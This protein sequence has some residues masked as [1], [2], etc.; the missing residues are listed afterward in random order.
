[1][2]EMKETQA[3]SL[4]W[5]DPLEKGMATHS[6]IPNYIKVNLYYIQLS[7]SFVV[8]NL[9]I[10]S[11]LFFY[12]KPYIS[13]LI[14]SFPI[15][16]VACSLDSLLTFPVGC[17][18]HWILNSKILKKK[19]F[20][21]AFIKHQFFLLLLSPPHFS[22]LGIF[23]ALC[24]SPPSHHLILCNMDSTL[25]NAA[26][27]K[28]HQKT[29]DC[30]VQ[31]SNGLS[32]PEHLDSNS[33]NFFLFLDTSLL[34]LELCLLSPLFS[35]TTL[36]FSFIA[37]LP[38]KI[39]IYWSSMM[40]PHLFLM[41]TLKMILWIYRFSFITYLKLASQ[42]FP[43]TLASFLSSKPVCA[44][45]VVSESLWPCGPTRLLCS[46]GFSRKEYWIGLP[47]PPPGDLPN[48]GIEP[49]SPD[50]RQILYH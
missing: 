49:R 46:W 43:Q 17:L 6:S 38:L 31:W 39:F 41:Y 47:C 12:G 35:L 5:E 20:N 19:V 25:T 13:L 27:F 30:S 48:L 9:N 45:S 7:N 21:S 32:S 22:K 37:I 10:W 11:S 36:S 24:S 50:G 18:T 3:R 29:P 8:Y 33:I 42:L 40:W 34:L 28:G 44:C 26:L 1:M 16:S 15:S 4:D 2:Q 14:P 23:P